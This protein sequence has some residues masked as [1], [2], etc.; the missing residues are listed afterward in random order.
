VK[1]TIAKKISQEL[2]MVG[3]TTAAHFNFIE[4]PVV[5]NIIAILFLHLMI[6]I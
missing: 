6:T 3:I 4:N 2:T 5:L 1:I